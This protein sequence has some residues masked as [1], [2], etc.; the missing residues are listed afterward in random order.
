M[1]T[2][3]ARVEVFFNQQYPDALAAALRTLTATVTLVGGLTASVTATI[4]EVET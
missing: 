3:T 4:V 1:T 2:R